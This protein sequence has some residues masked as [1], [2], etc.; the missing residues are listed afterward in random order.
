MI[1]LIIIIQTTHQIVMYEF[2]A[3][4]NNIDGWENY[5]G[6]SILNTCGGI[7]YFGSSNSQSY[8]I[9]RIIFDIESHSHIIVDA[10]FLGYLLFLITKVLIAIINL[11]LKQTRIQKA[12]YQ[13]Y[14]PKVRYV[15]VHNL[16]TCKLFQLFINI[17]EEL[18]GYILV[19]NREGQYHQNQ[20]W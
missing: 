6:I 1:I 19:N 17:I 8:S 4:S 11:I 15:V 7:R 5:H 14:H 2:N 13:L 9:S 12:M 16:N 3:S 20:V 18:F 10:Q